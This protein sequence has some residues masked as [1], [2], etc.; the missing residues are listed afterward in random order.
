LDA[1]EADCGRGE[2]FGGGLL[3]WPR[4]FGGRLGFVEMAAV[5]G[6]RAFN[7][8][9]WPR[10]E[11]GFT[12]EDAEEEGEEFCKQ[13]KARNGLV[14]KG[15]SVGGGFGGRVWTDGMDFGAGGAVRGG[16]AAG[17]AVGFGDRRE[18]S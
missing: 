7:L 18:W 17:E 16:G 4:F 6:G 12:A 9:K 3:E 5:L 15:F 1:E 13:E 11:E 8:L 2:I 10:G 14:W